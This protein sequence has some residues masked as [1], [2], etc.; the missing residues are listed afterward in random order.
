MPTNK[1]I[2][3]LQL[4]SAVTDDTLVPVDNS[5]QSYRTT[6]VQWKTY[7][8]PP[9]ADQR[10]MGNVSGTSAAPIAL[11]ATQVLAMLAIAYRNRLL[12]GGFD[13]WEAGTSVTVANSA[14][15]YLADQWYVK[16]GLGTNGVI[17]YSQQTGVTN[18][19]KYRAQVKITTAPT[20]AQATVI[21]LH[22]PLSNKASIE[23]YGATASFNILA[24]ALGNVNQVGV[25]FMYKTTEAKVDTVI[26]S[27]VLTTVNTSTFSLCSIVGQALGTSMTTAG[28]VGV[29]IRVTGVSSGNIYDI[30]NGFE[31]EQAM[32][33][34]G[35]VAPTFQRQCTH[36]ALELQALR[37]FY[38]EM[39]SEGAVSFQ[40]GAGGISVTNSTSVHHV[41]FPTKM[42]TTPTLAVS[43]VAHFTVSNA[44]AAPNPTGIAITT[45]NTDGC[46]INCT[47]LGTIAG[48]TYACMTGSSAS[49][50]IN[51]D[52]R[53]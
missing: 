36:P 14:T 2:P 1:T 31:V 43:N 15:T 45:P 22:Q 10:I 30:N 9:V 6:A 28:I 40:V 7:I 49:A 34:T 4:K 24:R 35:S 20:A 29:R 38:Y 21:E 23:L 12:N 53:I 46:R 41:A 13:F 44:S 52:A 5:I 3:N 39:N 48:N 47:G 33:A 27:E 37:H 11:T 8:N 19:S 51:F 26:G 16:N 18:G 50:R 25:Q 32:L 17:T 42:R